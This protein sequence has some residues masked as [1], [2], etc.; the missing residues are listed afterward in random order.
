MS[1]PT[2]LEK[3]WYDW[4]GFPLHKT[5]VASVS[6][7][8]AANHI[9]GDVLAACLKAVT[10]EKRSNITPQNV[11]S[12]WWRVYGPRPIATE[13]C[14]YCTGGV[15]WVILA[16]FNG[17]S[18]VVDY[19]KLDTLELYPESAHFHE[20]TVPC[21]QCSQGRT[22][23]RKHRYSDQVLSRLFKVSLPAG[24]P[25]SISNWLRCVWE[26]HCKSRDI[27]I[28]SAYVYDLDKVTQWANVAKMA[29]RNRIAKEEQDRKEGKGHGRMRS[30]K[31]TAAVSAE[32]SISCT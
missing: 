9:E 15:R 5:G 22:M 16:E 31:A 14:K 26:W 7:W 20:N 1:D 32:N 18:K 4:T 6:G 28:P 24:G 13:S 30:G 8:I 17:E 10:K 2:E 3:T 12:Y 21:S 23:N 25:N 29:A 19:R 27:P 11:K